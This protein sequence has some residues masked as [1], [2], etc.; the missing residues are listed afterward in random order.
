VGNALGLTIIQK[1]K[2]ASPAHSLR[3]FET[4]RRRE[5]PLFSGFF[6]VSAALRENRIFDLILKAGALSI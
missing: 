6:R 4:Q 2:T 5:K 3:S 1:I